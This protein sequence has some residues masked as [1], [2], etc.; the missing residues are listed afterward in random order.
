L[1]TGYCVTGTAS[2]I[3]HNRRDAKVTLYLK[4]C[5][6]IDD[7][8]GNR[9]PTFASAHVWCREDDY[10]PKSKRRRFLRTKPF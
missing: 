8:P 10:L 7:G 1:C 2:G 3:F 5:R 9:E 4:G 6:S